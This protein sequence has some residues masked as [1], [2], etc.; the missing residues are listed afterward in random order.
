MQAQ[1]STGA[2][3]KDF[4]AEANLFNLVVK[5]PCNI[6]TLDPLQI[7]DMRVK[8]GGIAVTQSVTLRTYDVTVNSV[9][10]DCQ[11]TDIYFN[12]STTKYD[13]GALSWLS[14]TRS[15]VGVG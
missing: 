11:G 5:H 9:S 3:T 1:D 7:Q 6:L 10:E 12:G 8:A 15:V 13:A 2:Y 4:S 14:A